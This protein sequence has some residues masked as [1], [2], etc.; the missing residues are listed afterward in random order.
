M[1]RYNL[2]FYGALQL[3]KIAYRNIF[4]NLRRSILSIVAIGFAVFIIGFM[5]SYIEG[6]LD[7]ATK[8][9]QVF[10]FGHIKIMTEDFE[11]KE[12]YSPLQ[13]PVNGLD[14]KLEFINGLDGVVTASPKIIS[15]ATFTNSIQKTGF[16]A[17][18]DFEK[19]KK[20]SDSDTKFA[21]YNFAKKHDGLLR[22]RFPEGNE[23][24]AVIGYRMAK[25][26]EIIPKILLKHEFKW[27]L[28]N[29]NNKDDKQFFIE[30]YN[31]SGNSYTLDIFSYE[32]KLNF[33]DGDIPQ[34]E[35]KD[36]MLLDRERYLDLLDIFLKLRISKLPDVIEEK[37]LI[38][39]DLF[40]K[41]YIKEIFLDLYEFDRNNGLYT[42]NKEKSISDDDYDILMKNIGNSVALRVPFKIISSQY[43][44]KFMIPTITGIIEYDY[45]NIDANYILVPLKR[46]QRLAGYRDQSQTLWVY[47]SNFSK[48]SKIKNA[49]RD[50]FGDE[51]IV[52]DWTQSSFL[53]MFEQ[54][55]FIYFVM[56]IIFLVV[57]S[58]LIIN[59]ITMVIQERIKEIGMM[60]ALGMKRMEIVAVFFFEAVILSLI[61]AVIGTMLTGGITLLTTNMPINIES[62]TGGVDFP[63]SNTIYIIFSPVILLKS[64]VFG[65]FI[66]SLCVLFPSMKS[67]F[68]EPVDAL[69]R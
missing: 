19:L 30:S 59:T 60:G 34:N 28:S 58:F 37:A 42:L 50:Q 16:A 46:M 66:T 27:L 3:I 31:L 10:E 14:E 1:K 32:N 9:A 5:M 36:K 11:K 6:M 35:L 21:Y 23:N 48:M 64:F 13:F 67:A 52:K 24:A 53:S 45:A 12:L 15:F 25:K 29:I 54:F 68:V 56:Y 39:Q 20:S 41:G 22:G 44:E 33:D 4:R 18:V 55:Q 63:V 8:V 65:M 62:M 51:I 61:G 69:R 43:S 26:M 49:I 47:I 2:S 40:I 38:V 17:G 57:A 7:S